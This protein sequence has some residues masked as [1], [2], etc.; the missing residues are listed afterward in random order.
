MRNGDKTADMIDCDYIAFGLNPEKK[1]LSLVNLE[2]YKNSDPLS[3]YQ[4]RSGR[5]VHLFEERGEKGISFHLLS[6][7]NISKG[8]K[9]DFL[10]AL[11][12]FWSGFKPDSPFSKFLN[13]YP[14]GGPVCFF[15]GSFNP[16]HEGHL[17]CARQCPNP[18]LV[19]VA[20]RNPFKKEEERP[21]C[22]FEH[23]LTVLRGFL[24]LAL[25]VYPGLLASGK[26]NPTSSWLPL[27]R[28]RKEL[29]LGEDSFHDV[30]SWIESEKVLKALE[31]IYVL[32]RALKK[33]LDSTSQK[34]RLRDHYPQLKIVFL[35]DHPFENLSSK[36]LRQALTRR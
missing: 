3:S 19:I 10:E 35:R 21:I 2:K 27:L 5:E 31:K 16:V 30:E 17:E 32:P 23:Y 36:G 22:A 26:A 18:R 7:K 15:G 9:T 11:A 20:D 29:L 24:P 33:V 13:F 28:G 12:L 8:A 14:S 1:I 4:L 6:P 25:P 34:N